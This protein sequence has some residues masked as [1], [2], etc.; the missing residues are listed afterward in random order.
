MPTAAINGQQ[1]H[2]QDTGGDG[3]AVVLAHGFLMDLD[4][5]APQVAALPD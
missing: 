4:M 5:F 1:I 2:F 3:P